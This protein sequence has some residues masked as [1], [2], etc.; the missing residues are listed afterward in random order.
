MSIATTHLWLFFFTKNDPFLPSPVYLRLPLRTP[1]E[2]ANNTWST[3]PQIRS[4]NR[5]KKSSRGGSDSGGGVFCG[6]SGVSIVSCGGA[7]GVDIL[8]AP[9]GLSLALCLRTPP[10][11]AVISASQQRPIAAPKMSG[12]F[13][14][15]YRNSNSATYSGR[16]LRLTLWKLPMI[17]R[18]NSDQKPS[19]VC[20]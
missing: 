5:T 11:S 7:G 2:M 16:Y 10:F 12:L 1:L 17:P 8:C 4:N 6:S 20:V 19:M 18:F 15:L 14:L 13:R 9:K 3:H